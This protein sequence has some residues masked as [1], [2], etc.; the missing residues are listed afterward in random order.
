MKINEDEFLKISAEVVSDIIGDE[1]LTSDNKVM[2]MLVGT[3]VL[4]KIKRKL[5]SE[6]E[7][8]EIVKE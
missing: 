6:T 1:E 4:G 3:M 5:F 2:V 8:I 7:E